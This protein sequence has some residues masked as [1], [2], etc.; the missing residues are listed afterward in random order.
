MQAALTCGICT[1]P[2]RAPPHPNA[3]KMLKC[4]HTLCGSCITILEGG[5]YARCPTCKADLTVLCVNMMLA[6]FGEKYYREAEAK[7]DRVRA[8]IAAR[9]AEEA[10]AEAAA[11]SG[12]ASVPP[13]GPV[14]TAAAPVPTPEGDVSGGPGAGVNGGAVGADGHA[15]TTIA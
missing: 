10:A 14:E 9:E 3:P 8:R 15:S 5:D 13:P 11:T 6:E 12:A 2:Y 1:D 7:R 4:G